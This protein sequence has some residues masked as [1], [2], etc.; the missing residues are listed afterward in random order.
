MCLRAKQTRLPFGF[1]DNKASMPFDLV[2]FDIWGPYYVKSFCGASYFLAILDDA[3]CCVWVH[4]M[5]DKVKLL[6]LCKNFVPWCKLNLR[7]E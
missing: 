3:T 6:N 1:S 4:L 2:H 7:Q 5:R